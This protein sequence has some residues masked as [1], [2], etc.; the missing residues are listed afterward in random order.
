MYWLFKSSTE[1]KQHCYHIN[2]SYFNFYDLQMTIFKDIK[3][4]NYETYIE[5]VLYRLFKIKLN[6]VVILT[7]YKSF[8]LN[9]VMSFENRIVNQNKIF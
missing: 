7:I 2:E 6:Q 4:M 3:S 5:I 1:K 8:I 9:N